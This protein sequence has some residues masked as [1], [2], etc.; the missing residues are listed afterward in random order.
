M[1]Q[2]PDGMNAFEFAAL[3]GLRASQLRRG[4]TPRVPH[5]HTV[6]V[7][8]QHEIAGRTVV[9]VVALPLGDPEA[10]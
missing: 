1:V 9:R 6:A 5:S 3:S 2:R 4:C 10:A 8:A 7:T